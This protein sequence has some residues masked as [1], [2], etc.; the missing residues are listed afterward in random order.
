M[1]QSFFFIL[2][3][4]LYSL[5]NATQVVNIKMARNTSYIQP[6]KVNGK[7]KNDYF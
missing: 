7:Q 4:Y 5:L 3:H 1:F 2:T 6:N